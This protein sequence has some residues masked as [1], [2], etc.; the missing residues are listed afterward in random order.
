M[1]GTF[2]PIHIGHLILAEQ[3]YEQYKLD[4]VL[5]MPSKKPPHKP[6][7]ELE[8]DIHRKK[9][10]ELSIQDNSHFILSTLELERDSTTYTVDTMRELKKNNPNTEYYF[11]IGGDSLFQLETWREPAEIMKHTRIL[12]ASRY[13]I[14]N[15][16]IQNQIDYLKKTYQGWISL[17][18]IP[19]IDISSKMLRHS[20]QIGKSVTYYM[21]ES[22]IEYIRKHNLYQ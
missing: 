4:C 10:V 3:A 20:L 7:Q 5:F 17:L 9:M 6:N 8:S 2:N 11:I 21:K 18:E 22:V 14:P 19:T 16:E 15:Q 12:A 1:G 13:H